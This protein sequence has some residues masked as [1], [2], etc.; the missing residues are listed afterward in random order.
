MIEYVPEFRLRRPGGQIAF[1]AASRIF[2]GISPWRPISFQEFWPPWFVVHLRCWHLT[3]LRLWYVTITCGDT[4]SPAA[5]VQKSCPRLL[6]NTSK[7]FGLFLPTSERFV[8]T[9]LPPKPPQNPRGRQKVSQPGQ[10]APGPMRN[11]RLPTNMDRG[12][13][14]GCASSCGR[15]QR[16]DLLLL[17]RASLAGIQTAL[18]TYMGM[19]GAR[20]T[21]LLT[22][23]LAFLI[24]GAAVADSPKVRY[25]RDILPLLSDRCFK[26]HG[27]DS[28][29][30]QAGL[31][32]DRAED[33]TPSWI[34]AASDRARQ[35]RGERLVERIE[36]DDRGIRDAAGRQRQDASAPKRRRCCV[37]GSKRERSTSRIGRS[38]RPSAPRC[39]ALRHAGA[40][41]QSDRCVRARAA[42]S[43]GDRTVAAGEQRA[44]H[45]PVVF[46]S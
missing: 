28:A 1:P 4:D 6:D 46:R 26:C 45:S 8:P 24:S 37:A 30:R 39:R 16:A 7:Y 2:L 17:T 41:A 22:H 33:A 20:S 38:W 5:T 29:S 12:N 14:E 19:P 43:R 42:G 40:G 34:L 23:V 9:F 3:R 35:R 27:P 31:R 13:I 15:V 32:L 44:A 10:K 21:W 25:R 11:F 18:E 36:S